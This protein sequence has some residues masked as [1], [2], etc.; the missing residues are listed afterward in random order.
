MIEHW[1]GRYL[2]TPW[3]AGESDCWNL[4]RQVWREQFARDVAAVMF[5]AT[6]AIE[7]RRILRDGDWRCWEMTET[8]QEGD[9]VL[10]ARG[11]SP[12]HV[13]IYLSGSL[14]LHS[15]EGAG[16]ICTPIGDLLRVG[17]RVAGYYMWQE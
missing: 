16:V 13:G 9:A 8:P 5:D 11:T 4:A 15:V 6:S 14:V 3:V 10:M 12:C 7:T 1:A 17:Y 2:G